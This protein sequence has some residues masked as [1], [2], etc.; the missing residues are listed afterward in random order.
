MHTR[1][2]TVVQVK[3]VEVIRAAGV[4]DA[5]RSGSRLKSDDMGYGKLLDMGYD[6]RLPLPE[7]PQPP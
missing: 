7:M 2:K 5:A 4:I 3:L 6:D 1:T